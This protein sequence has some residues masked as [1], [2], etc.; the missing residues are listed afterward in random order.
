LNL[1]KISG[2]KVLQWIRKQPALAHLRVVILTSTR[3]AGDTERAFAL[4][5]N[6][7]LNKPGNF[8]QL[9]MLMNGLEL[10]WAVLDDFR[11]ES[12]GSKVNAHSHGSDPEEWK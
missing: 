3:Q 7:Y 4:G 2:L 9:V 1:P 11:Q 10:R 8:E 6:S 12:S 5:A